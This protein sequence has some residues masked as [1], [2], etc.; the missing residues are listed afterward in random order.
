MEWL[1]ENEPGRCRN[2]RPGACGPAPRH[3]PRCRTSLLLASLKRFRLSSCGAREWTYE[4][5]HMC[6]CDVIVSCLVSEWF[7]NKLVLW[8]ARYKRYRFSSFSSF[9]T[10]FLDINCRVNFENELLDIVDYTICSSLSFGR[11]PVAQV[12]RY[13]GLDCGY[14]VPA[15]SQ[16]HGLQKIVESGLCVVKTCMF[17][18][19]LKIS[20][21]TT[22]TISLV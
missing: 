1:S 5:Q 3:I 18:I 22:S 9:F 2:I 11:E 6:G 20:F 17:E 12:L 4:H 8:C 21:K 19:L 16:F 15:V 10:Y 14:I 13:I 7:P